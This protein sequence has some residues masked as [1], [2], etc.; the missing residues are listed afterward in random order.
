MP[1]QSLSKPFKAD[2][3]GIQPYTQPTVC[4]YPDFK[5]LHFSL[6]LSDN[7]S[8]DYAHSHSGVTPLMAV[9]KAGHLPSVQRLL[10]L[11][12]SIMLKTKGEFVVVKL[13]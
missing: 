11:G 8:V 6:I 1:R 4:V 7:V 2:F 12:A 9:C 13:M 10:R 5:I 3:G